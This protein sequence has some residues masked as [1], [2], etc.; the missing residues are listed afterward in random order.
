[1]SIALSL[2]ALTLAHL[3]G[4]DGILAAF[5]AGVAF[6]MRIDRSEEFGQQKVQEAISRLCNLPVFVLFGAMLPWAEWYRLGMGA[7]LFAV[8]VLLLRRPG[9]VLLTAAA[10]MRLPR[11]D[12]V[13]LGWFGPIGVAAIYYALLAKERTGDPL[14]WHAGSLVIVLSV[15]AHGV[16]SAAGIVAY[17]RSKRRAETSA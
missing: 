2:F 11:R 13:F 10:G 14:Y 4:S 1:M 3:V 5:A 16:T 7:V 15:L 12:D 17:R 6:N 8:A 9:A